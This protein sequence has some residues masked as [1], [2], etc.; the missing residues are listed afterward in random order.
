M[1]RERQGGAGSAIFAQPSLDAVPDFAFRNNLVSHVLEPGQNA[2]AQP[3]QKAAR[4]AQA[5]HIE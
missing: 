3:D 4:A 2:F 1:G 5:Q